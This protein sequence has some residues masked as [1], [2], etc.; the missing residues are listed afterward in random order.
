MAK[1]LTSII[2]PVRTITPYVRETVD[3]IL[4]Q[5]E[6]RLEIIIVT[7]QPE[8]LE[9]T[10]IIAS[11]EP[12]PAYKRNLGAKVAKGEIL[13]FLDDDSYPAKDWLMSALSV[14]GESKNIT[15]VC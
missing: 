4:K 11:G 2:I 10:K 1:I 13:A 9:G 5:S 14:F 12:T 8:K 7:D 3:H 6:K 15:A